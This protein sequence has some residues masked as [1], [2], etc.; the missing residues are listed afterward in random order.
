[1][2]PLAVLRLTADADE[3]WIIAALAV[4]GAA[5]VVAVAR[6]WHASGRGRG[7][8]PRDGAAFGGGLLALAFAL[9]GPLDAWTGRSFAAHMTQHEILMLVAAPLLVLGRPLAAWT[10]LLPEALHSQAR[11]A[12]ASPVR[13]R[14]W[15]SLTRPVGATIFQLVVVWVLHVPALFDYAA[16][17]APA[18][19]AQH[20]AFLASALC[21]WWAARVPAIRNGG[22]EA[23]LGVSLGCLFVS[24]L[25]TGA[26][27]ALLTFASRPW[28]AIYANVDSPWASG[29]LEDQQLG[30]LI[31]WIPGGTVYVVA[32]LVLATR[33]LATPRVGRSRVGPALA[34][35]N[36]SGTP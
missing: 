21:F 1:M 26:L 33:A 5:Y 16:T 12:L 28:Y 24:M 4:A 7:I 17:H 23:R 19:A 29:A 15:R 3:A 31:M 13:A 2:D 11:S 18:H 14:V 35:A 10:W 9:L 27:G 34:A 22:V 32:A 6:L 36:D 25:A 20:A 8:R 30:G